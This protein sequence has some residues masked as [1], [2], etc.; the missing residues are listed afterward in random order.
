MAIAYAPGMLST[1]HLFRV[2]F[3]SMLGCSITAT[4]VAQEYRIK[5]D[6]PSK[7]GDEML[8][9]ATAKSKEVREA[10]VG[11]EKRSRV[12]EFTAELQG[13]VKV[14]AVNAHT[15]SAT[16]LSCTV[17]KLLKD[18]AAMYPPGTVIVGEKRNQADRFTIDG[19]PVRPGEVAALS[20]VMELTDPDRE[21]SP[22]QV[23]GTDQPQKVGSKWPVNA[24]RFADQNADS[25]L[26]IPA[27]DIKGQSTLVEVKK[28][29]DV[30]TMRV[31]THITADGFKTETPRATLTGK[32]DLVVSGV[33]PVDPNL[34]G[35]SMSTKLNVV[36]TG[37]PNSGNPDF[38]V[39]LTRESTREQTPVKK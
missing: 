17:D 6:R 23:S 22:D 37:T 1:H 15:G 39:T 38:T 13:T 25:K 35:T 21:T 4:A 27:E 20:A 5:L 34:P 7:V 8:V 28:V 29:G 36:M 16:K 26:P 14:L 31:E 33:L 32:F 18:D 3:G 10:V 30:D 12:E 19:H 24:D 9:H 11:G 2:C